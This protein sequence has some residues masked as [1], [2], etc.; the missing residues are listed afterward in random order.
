MSNSCKYHTH[1]VCIAIINRILILNRTSW[2]NN[3]ARGATCE[4]IE[5]GS[6]LSEIAIQATDVLKMDYAGVD[7]I[8]DSEGHYSVIEVNSIPAWKGLESVCEIKMAD[9]LAEDL[10]GRCLNYFKSPLKVKAS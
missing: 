5:L 3:V 8:Q 9:L 6:K 7:I 1:L 10:I 2:L 4:R